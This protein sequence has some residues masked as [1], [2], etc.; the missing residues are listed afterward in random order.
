M[1]D[2]TVDPDV[3]DDVETEVVASEPDAIT[4]D[5]PTDVES[6]PQNFKS[7]RALADSYAHAQ[8]RMNSEMQTRRELE[9]QLAE[10]EE[11]LN[12]IYR[13]SEMKNEYDDA[14]ATGDYREALALVV[15][16]AQRATREELG[17]PVDAEVQQALQVQQNAIAEAV[18][19]V[20]NA[21]GQETWQSV[22]PKLQQHGD[23]RLNAAVQT[24]NPAA[25][26]NALFDAVNSINTN[27]KYGV[28]S[29]VDMTAQ[30]L[31]AQS[32][33]GAAG[34]PSPASA[35][36]REWQSIKNAVEPGRYW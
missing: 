6:L 1:S 29:T 36:E 13:K 21:L 19:Y 5:D 34:R 16:E 22:A 28:R 35:D 9:K 23:V 25:I 30:K 27:E 24:G 10:Y 12:E 33:P 20:E 11:Y 8:R 15:Q 26:A 32:L 2:E 31:A 18:T 17:V 14:L 4:V 7:V 3:G